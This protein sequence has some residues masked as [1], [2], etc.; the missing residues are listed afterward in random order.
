M[1]EITVTIEAEVN[2]TEDPK[3]VK[4]AIENLFTPFSTELLA[5]DRGSLFILK[6]KGKEGVIKFYTLLRQERILNAARR[7]LT[8]G[9]S[10]EGITF[11]L[12]KQAAYMKRVSFCDPIGESPL[13]PI[14]VKIETNDPRTVIDWLAP[15]IG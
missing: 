11:C 6:V 2:P 14:R 15:R 8:K 7:V 12:N 13:G 9:V 10:S 3:K 5:E 1:S 4:T